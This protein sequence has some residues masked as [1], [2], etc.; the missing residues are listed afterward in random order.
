ME[1]RNYAVFIDLENTGG[2]VNTL[3]KVIEK[4]KIRGDIL[5]G[6][7]YGY[8]EC[9]SGLKETLLSNTFNVLPS[10]R[11]GVNQKNNLDI[12]LVIDAL[13]VA[14]T[15]PLIDCFCIVSGDSDYTPLVGKLK[16]MGKFVLGISRSEVASNI[17]IKACNE[18]IFLETVTTGKRDNQQKE[19]DSISSQKELVEVV[20]KI[21]EDQADA[22]GTMFVSELKKTLLRLK[23]DFNEKNYGYNSF[24]RLLTNLENKYGVIR[25][26]GE[27]NSLKVKLNAENPTKTGEIN[28]VNWAAIFQEK[29]DEFKQN[30]FR[31]VNPSIIK[32]EIQNDYPDFDERQIG[33]KKF[34]D[35]MKRLEKDNKI[36]I[37]FNEAKTM[38]IKIL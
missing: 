26:F 25:L 16:S 22:D 23:P 1:K 28:R 38:L 3:K 5:I 7:V 13:E 15:N 35:I 36:S 31:R 9:F 10:I 34:S 17:F 27:Y 18:F 2:N 4:V 11:Y 19:D 14:Y 21:I 29:L 20:K 6:K 37:E 8:Q 33:F 24:G 12:Q 32:A 30:G